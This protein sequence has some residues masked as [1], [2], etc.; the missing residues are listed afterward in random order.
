M[1]NRNWAC[2]ESPEKRVDAIMVPVYW[3]WRTGHINT[4]ARE[5]LECVSVCFSS[6]SGWWTPKWEWECVFR[7]P[8]GA[9]KY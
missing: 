3:A 9:N 2:Y 5:Q 1:L 4:K 6:S 7:P 8:K